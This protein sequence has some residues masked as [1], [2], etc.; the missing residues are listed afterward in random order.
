MFMLKLP[1]YLYTNKLVVTL[2]LDENRGVNNVMYQRTLTI[3]KGLKNTVQIQF[4]NSDQKPVP[5]TDMTFVFNA[6]SNDNRTLL[7][8]RLE[9][10]DDGTTLATRGLATLTISE[11][12]TLDLDTTFYKFSITALDSDGSYMPAYSNT[13]YG[14]AG[15]LEVKSEVLPVLMPSTEIN[16]WWVYRNANPDA[17]RFEFY[18]GNYQA[19]AGFKSNEALHTAAIYMTG[20]T[21]DVIIQGTLDN[22]PASP[23]HANRGYSEIRDLVTEPSG[24]SWAILNALSYDNFTGID[25]VNWSGNFTNVQVKWIPK[26]K[27]IGGAQTNYLPPSAPNNPTVGK[28]YYPFGSVDKVL[29]R[30]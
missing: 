16:A 7:S 13:Y 26:S 17:Q 9:I 22:S 1:V 5:V 11:S 18:S 4:K 3:Q 10:V 23:G 19:H 28:A 6:F 8:K 24:D 15:T 20:F 21:G 27:N 29:Y 2:D 14:I 12:D 30:S 25:Y